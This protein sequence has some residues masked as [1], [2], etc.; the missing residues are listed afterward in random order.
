M[1]REKLY[2]PVIEQQKERVVG[3]IKPDRVRDIVD[4]F[5]AGDEMIG[6]PAWP[7]F[8]THGVLVS[9]DQ[10]TADGYPFQAMYVDNDKVVQEC[11]H[12]F[13]AGEY[14]VMFCENSMEN[15]PHV[16]KLIEH[17]KQVGFDFEPK[18]LVEQVSGPVVEKSKK[19]F[20]VKIM[21]QKRG[22]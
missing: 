10:I 6:D 13:P 15:N 7:H 20:L 8:Y 22:I 14:L 3:L 17:A 1:V 21:L 9:S 11:S 5:D 16:A 12:C 2:N 19:E 18:I 4:Y